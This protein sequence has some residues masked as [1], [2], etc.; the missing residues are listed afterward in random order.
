[1]DLREA[2]ILRDKHMGSLSTL[3]IVD[4]TKRAVSYFIAFLRKAHK[5][6]LKNCWD[7]SWPCVMQTTE[8][9]TIQKE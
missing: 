7:Y 6:K 5:V 2:L 9:E 8:G 3:D 4:K 1:M